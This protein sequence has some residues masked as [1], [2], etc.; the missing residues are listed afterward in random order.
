METKYQNGNQS[1]RCKI[2]F[3]NIE[4]PETSSRG[5]FSLPELA[6]GTPEEEQ[7]NE[8][9]GTEERDDGNESSVEDLARDDSEA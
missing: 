5:T 2:F 6:E 9:E 8:V 3:E 4:I 7:E 1:S